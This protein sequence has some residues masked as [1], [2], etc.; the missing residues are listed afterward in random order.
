MSCTK[1]HGQSFG[2]GTHCKEGQTYCEQ[3]TNLMKVKSEDVSLV[4]DD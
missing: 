2:V 4:R 1:G 3:G